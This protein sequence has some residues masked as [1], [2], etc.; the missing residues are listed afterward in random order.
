MS[1][2]RFDELYRKVA[3]MRKL[4]RAWF[5]G[6]HTRATLIAAKNAERAV[7]KLVEVLSAEIE[8]AAS[9]QERLDISA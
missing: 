1:P 3:A 7:D 2:L 5:A 4:Q 6:D 8:D 9:G